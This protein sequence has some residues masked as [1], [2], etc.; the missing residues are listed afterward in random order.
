MAHPPTLDDNDLRT[1]EY[2]YLT[3]TGRVSGRAHTV[4][5]WFAIADDAVWFF[6][7]AATDWMQNAQHTA[8]VRVRI[9]AWMW[10]ADA[11][12]ELA[13]ATTESG[14]RARAEM[15]RKYQAGYG[16]PLDGWAATATG[17]AAVVHEPARATTET[18]P[19]S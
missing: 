11:R 9:G 10:D 5:L 7:E 1:A 15:L 8:S 4:E 16:E 18:W 17:L 3:T 19:Q 12:I 14:Q 2:A 6:T 13:G